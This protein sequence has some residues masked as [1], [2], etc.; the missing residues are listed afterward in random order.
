MDY[1]HLFQDMDMDD[2]ELL[3][4]PNPSSPNLIPETI[5]NKQP[6]WQVEAAK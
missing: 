4:T 5:N 3:N 6:G 2:I 1:S